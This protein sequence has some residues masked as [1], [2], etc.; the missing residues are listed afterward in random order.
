ML[1]LRTLGVFYDRHAGCMLHACNLYASCIRFRR[2]TVRNRRAYATIA[3]C[4][5]HLVCIICAF[6]G[7]GD[8]RLT[9]VVGLDVASS[10]RFVVAAATAIAMPRKKKQNK[11]KYNKYTNIFN[12]V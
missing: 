10:G 3:S 1:T 6:H 2:R 12:S 4:Q 5:I 9:A 7:D 11:Y 8:G